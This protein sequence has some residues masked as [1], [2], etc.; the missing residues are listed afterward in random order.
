MHLN[1]SPTKGVPIGQNVT[2]LS[3]LGNLKIVKERRIDAVLD[4]AA[5]FRNGLNNNRTLQSTQKT[6]RLQCN[7]DCAWTR[8]SDRRCGDCLH[9]NLLLASNRTDDFADCANFVF[10]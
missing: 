8:T 5:A 6:S 7:R 4:K 9:C 10:R 1:A 2:D 3:A